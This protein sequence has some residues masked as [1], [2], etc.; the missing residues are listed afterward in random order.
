MAVKNEL[1]A[2]CY[3]DASFDTDPDD[4]QV[5]IRVRVFIMNGGS[6]MLERV[7]SKPLVAGFINGGGICCC[8]GS[9]G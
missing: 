6:S 9:G 2:R 4:S 5:S 7:P 3:V 1:V 8:F